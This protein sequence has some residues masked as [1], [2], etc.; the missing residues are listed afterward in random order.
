[1]AN[2]TLAIML[3]TAH[4]QKYAELTLGSVLRHLTWDGHLR[5]HIASDGDSK[6][7]LAGLGRLAHD[8]REVDTLSYTN[9]MGKGY[10]ANY[11]LATQIVHEVA[12]Y[13]LPLEDDWECLRELDANALCTALDE[14]G[15][16]ACIRLGYVGFTQSLRAE[17]VSAA[18][19]HYLR[20]DESSP[21]PH[22]FAGH[23]RIETRGWERF[24]GP[25]PE[26]KTPGETEFEVAHNPNARK[27]VYWPVGLVKPAGDLFGHIGTE[28]SY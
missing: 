22:V 5:V 19:V 2:K 1:M 17:F 6:E 9:S 12:D 7:Y 24:V 14:L 25:W 20:F 18:G 3:L 21:E 11:N 10:G 13:I 28:R 26:G 4:R 23:P 15:G 8:F 27:Y 16:N